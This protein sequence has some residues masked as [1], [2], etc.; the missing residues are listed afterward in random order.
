MCQQLHYGPYGS[1]DMLQLQQ[2][3]QKKKKNYGKIEFLEPEH[4]KFEF[5]VLFEAIVPSKISIEFTYSICYQ[6]YT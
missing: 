2:F 6:S 5:S 1:S 4:A 3:Q